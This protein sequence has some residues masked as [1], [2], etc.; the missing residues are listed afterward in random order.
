LAT[1]DN[2]GPHVAQIPDPFILLQAARCPL[3]ISWIHMSEHISSTL[4]ENMPSQIK[5]CPCFNF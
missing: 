2:G 1:F 3:I 5:V 4:T